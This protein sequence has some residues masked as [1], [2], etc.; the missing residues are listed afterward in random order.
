LSPPFADDSPDPPGFLPARNPAFAGR[1]PEL[2]K[3]RAAMVDRPGAAVI[4]GGP[5]SGKTA[6]ACE[7]A[8]RFAREFNG[9]F[10]VHSGDRP[11]VELAGEIGAQMRRRMAGDAAANL[12]ELASIFE[13]KRFLLVLD[14]VTRKPALMAGGRS[15]TLLT[16][17]KT[18][19]LAGTPGVKLEAP[20]ALDQYCSVIVAA[21][22]VCAPAGFSI[23][24]AAEIAG[25]EVDGIP[26]PAQ[27]LDHS[28]FRCALPQYVIDRT[29]LTGELRLRHAEAASRQPVTAD[30]L[31]DLF[32]AFRWSMAAPGRWD[33]A[34]ELARRIIAFTQT[35]G[36]VAEAFEV[37][38]S[39]SAEAE[40]REDW[41][42]LN[43]YARERVWTLQSWGRE[44]E[45]RALEKRSRKWQFV[46]LTLPWHEGWQ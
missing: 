8:N 31:P 28:S 13:G 40:K 15:S 32:H 39:L 35:E 23:S 30:L 21:M 44:A 18:R 37:M 17:R 22:A 43:R 45:A 42:T 36:R 2:E 41:K 3:L 1:E 26:Q 38:E 25:M 7:F 27:A 20:A 33:L 9:V 6:L 46:Q 24:L 12:R 4:R 10:W 14:H 29:L 34:C 5:G 19:L 11:P 16:T